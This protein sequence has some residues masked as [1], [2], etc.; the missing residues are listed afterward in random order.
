MS[1]SVLETAIVSTPRYNEY[2]F[3][4]PKQAR[5][6]QPKTASGKTPATPSNH[7]TNNNVGVQR[8][9]D[10]QAVI[11]VTKDEVIMRIMQ[12]NGRYA[13]LV[14]RL[15]GRNNAIY[16]SFDS[17]DRFNLRAYNRD[18][19]ENNLP[20]EICD[21]EEKY[22]GFWTDPSGHRVLIDH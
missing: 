18:R 22:H 3:T 6:R 2:P 1:L 5:G 20:P 4:P 17:L 10:K 15:N 13:V 11:N 21:E 12:P 19:F 7:N 9:L 14:G 16:E 8:Q